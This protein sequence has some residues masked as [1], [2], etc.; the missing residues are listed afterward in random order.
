M[1][2]C[3]EYLRLNLRCSLLYVRPCCQSE[4]VLNTLLPPAT[5]LANQRQARTVLGQ[6]IASRAGPVWHGV[7]SSRHG[8]MHQLTRSIHYSV[9]KLHVPA[10]KWPKTPTSNTSHVACTGR[11]PRQ[12]LLIVPDNIRTALSSADCI[13]WPGWWCLF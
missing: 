4:S 13:C 10:L 8:L 3:P 5:I 7:E 12:R 2:N 1:F 9:L 11:H 6:K